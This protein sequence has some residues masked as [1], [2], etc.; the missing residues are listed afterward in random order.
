MNGS[1]EA[2]EDPVEQLFAELLSCLVEIKDVR[3]H[4]LEDE[5]RDIHLRCEK[6]L[7]RAGRLESQ[8][9]F[10]KHSW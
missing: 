3:L 10:Q 1:I 5:I 8:L 7:D 4:M 2:R 9:V 6:A